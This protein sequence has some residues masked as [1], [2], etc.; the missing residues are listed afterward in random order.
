MES[1]GHSG[2]AALES[3]AQALVETLNA[4][5]FRKIITN[6][7]PGFNTIRNERPLSDVGPL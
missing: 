3:M 1:A 5:E 6:F 7:P 2:G 4:Y